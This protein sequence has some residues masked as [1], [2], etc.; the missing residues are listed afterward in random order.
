MNVTLQRRYRFRERYRDRYCTF[1]SCNIARFV[2][3]VYAHEQLRS[4]AYTMLVYFQF[5]R[6]C[7][8]KRKKRGVQCRRVSVC[9]CVK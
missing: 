7:K 1:S 9:V 3:I 8:S 2:G 6:E 5:A 4:Y